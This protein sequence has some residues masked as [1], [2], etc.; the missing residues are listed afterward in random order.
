MLFVPAA[1]T[2][3][4]SQRWTRVVTSVKN[5]GD[6]I[7]LRNVPLTRRNQDTGDYETSL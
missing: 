6:Q 2:L 5:V 3:S 7:L 4:F 1:L